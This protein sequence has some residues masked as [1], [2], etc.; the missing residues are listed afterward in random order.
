MCHHCKIPALTAGMTV[1][2]YIV[3]G[4]ADSLNKLIVIPAK[5]GIF[6]NFVIRFREAGPPLSR[7]RQP[8]RDLSK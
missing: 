8:L 6:K 4:T 2:L 5:A 3:S 7:E 1:L